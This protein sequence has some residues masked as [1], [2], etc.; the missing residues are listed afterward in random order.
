M[1]AESG[2]QVSTW[3]LGGFGVVGPFRL[4]AVTEILSDDLCSNS[5]SRS[6]MRY[7]RPADTRPG[8]CGRCELTP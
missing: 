3:C 4:G 2:A 5:V 8:H 1:G 6:V 7:S